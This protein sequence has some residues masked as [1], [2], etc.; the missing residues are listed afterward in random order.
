M[1]S[2]SYALP[3]HLK[4]IKNNFTLEK[5][6]LDRDRFHPTYIKNNYNRLRNIYLSTS[7]MK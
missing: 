2:N 5:H 4:E 6:Y 7:S 1:G 3:H